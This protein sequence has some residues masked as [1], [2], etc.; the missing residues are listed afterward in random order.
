MY[1]VVVLICISCWLMAVNLPRACLPSVCPLKCFRVFG[2]RSNQIVF[3]CCNVGLLY[4]ACVLA[5]GPV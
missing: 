5:L 1:L 4:L 3:S 2:R